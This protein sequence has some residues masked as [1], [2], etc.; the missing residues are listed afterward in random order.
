MAPPKALSRAGSGLVM[1]L[2]RPSG[3]A[4]SL[5][6][7]V[8]VDIADLH[9]RPGQRLVGTEKRFLERIITGSPASR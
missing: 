7:L 4:Q 9:S 5:V 1:A 2:P 6:A 8:K 3:S